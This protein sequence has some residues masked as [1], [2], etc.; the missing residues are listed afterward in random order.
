MLKTNQLDLRFGDI[1]LIFFPYYEGD[2]L[3]H[4]Q[5]PGLVLYNEPEFEEIQL[6]MISSTI[7]TTKISRIPIAGLPK[8]S[9]IYLAKA[10]TIKYK[11]I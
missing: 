11:F 2:K 7:R 10:A 6:A 1:V 8:E 9:M 3:H 5:R 4:K